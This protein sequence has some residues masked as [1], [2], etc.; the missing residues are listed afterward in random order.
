[1]TEEDREVLI[2]YFRRR[3]H[4]YYTERVGSGVRGVLIL[5][6]VKGSAEA[7]SIEFTVPVYLVLFIVSLEAWF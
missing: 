4:G 7:A 2:W 1:V 5:Y 3:W 6:M